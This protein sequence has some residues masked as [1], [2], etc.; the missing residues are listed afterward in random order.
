MSK[1]V[2]EVENKRLLS[3]L[4]LELELEHFSLFSY[5][6]VYLSGKAISEEEPRED[7]VQFL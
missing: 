4:E 7:K 2:Q 5:H 1:G 3:Q 6:S